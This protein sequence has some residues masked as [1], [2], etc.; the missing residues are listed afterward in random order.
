MPVKLTRVER[1]QEFIKNINPI[2]TD[3]SSEYWLVN[4]LTLHS[5]DPKPRY[6]T[7]Y[8][9]L[10]LICHPMLTMNVFTKYRNIFK[11]L[12]NIE[13]N[14]NLTFEFIQENLTT[15]NWNWTMVSKHK[16]ITP[17]IVEQNIDLPWC[18]FGLSENPNL[19]PE[20]I[21]KNINNGW[22]WP[23]I[24][25][26]KCITFDMIVNNPDLPW[27]Y[28]YIAL[29]KPPIEYIINN[30][31]IPFD[32]N[33]LTK[34]QPT[35]VIINNP[36]LPW[37]YITLLDRDDVPIEYVI[38]LLH[39]FVNNKYCM[40]NISKHAKY[41]DIIN[42]PEI[43][44]HWSGL[45]CN[46]NLTE[47]FILNNFDNF[48]INQLAMFAT[49]TV[50]II[51]THK[52]K[53]DKFSCWLSIT[54]NHSI[55]QQDI[56]NNPDLPWEGI[57]LNPNVSEAFALQYIIQNDDNYYMLYDNRSN[58]TIDTIFKHKLYKFITYALWYHNPKLYSSILQK[59]YVESLKP[60]LAAYR[61]QQWW[62][63]VTTDYKY[64][65][66]RR[67]VAR[68]YEDTFCTEYQATNVLQTAT[69]VN[70]MLTI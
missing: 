25:L 8:I 66:C 5:Q 51:R 4:T 65:A 23:A 30:L 58:I 13:S 41:L 69:N 44:W 45:S 6:D 15:H 61:I 2:V 54:Q 64:A 55:T 9:H 26:N 16:N 20:F 63:K 42:H 17:Q 29:K 27:I 57:Y 34:R 33:G 19:T 56:E 46:K 36:Q 32:W 21:R 49:L 31:H 22:S 62:F 52:A 14:P 38:S 35:S 59:F 10:Q 7:D 67:K 39:I 24:M 37:N 70:S 11:S 48:N 60:Y 40:Q 50:K 43:P 18:Y 68:D 28:N 53:F 12:K 1:T 47:E 3:A